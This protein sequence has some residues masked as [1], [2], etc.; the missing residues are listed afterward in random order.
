MQS[1]GLGVLGPQVLLGSPCPVQESFRLDTEARY[2][3][4]LSIT[5]LFMRGKDSNVPR[6]SAK[7]LSTAA[8][9]G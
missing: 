8:A 1:P 9:M 3:L 5:F 6:V 2:P 4:P 7:H